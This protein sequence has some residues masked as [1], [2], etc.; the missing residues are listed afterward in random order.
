MFFCYATLLSVLCSAFAAL[1]LYAAGAL[2]TAGSVYL[3]LLAVSSALAVAAEA[4]L[5]IGRPG[6]GRRAARSRE[7]LTS[8]QSD[9]ETDDAEAPAHTAGSGYQSIVA[10]V[11]GISLL[12]GGLYLYDHLSHPAQAGY[13]WMAWTGPPITGDIVV[14]SKGANLSFQIVHRQ[15]NPATFRLAATWLGTPSRPLSKSLN[16]SIGPNR[17]FRGSLFVPPLPNGCTYRVMITLTAAQQIDPLTRSPQ[18][19]SINADVYDPR[20]SSRKC[21]Q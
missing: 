12:A 19:W 1:M 10:L 18:I 5:L 17:T 9:A 14:G 16:F 8:D 21:T 11:T 15:P 2:I 3:C 4:R 6:K 20:K 7:S 13:T